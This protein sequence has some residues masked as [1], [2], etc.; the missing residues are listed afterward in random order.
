[1]KIVDV[2]EFYAERGGGVRTY[3]EQKLRAA[4]LLDHEVVVVAPGARDREEPRPGGRIIWLAA[5]KLPVDR[6]YHVFVRERAIWQV[7]DRERADVIEGS[8]PWG[9]GWAVARYR[10]RERAAPLKT[11]V[12]HHD[13]V[14]VYPQT[15]LGRA[16]GEARV[17]RL[18]APAWDYLR[19]LSDGF[20]ATIT[21][22]QSLARRLR[23]F[24]LARPIA[25]PF[26]VDKQVFG[27]ALPDPGLRSQLV[28]AAGAAAGAPLL[29]VLSRLHP[30]K[31]IFS[32]IE[33]IRRVAQTRPIAAV[34]FGDGPLRE[35]VKLAAKRA[36]IHLGGVV[37]DR[38]SLARALASADALLHGSAAETYGLVVAEALSA[39]LPLIVPSA[40]G[41][42]DLAEPAH[43]E[44]YPA[45][46]VGACADAIVR[47]LDRDR[48]RLRAAARD[49]AARLVRTTEQH[50]TDLFATYRQLRSE[51]E[52]GSSAAEQRAAAGG[53]PTGRASATSVLG[54]AVFERGIED[55][56]RQ[57]R[58]PQS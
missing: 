27:A 2:A 4:A 44:T 8:S 17:D 5:P 12:F 1:M 36:P 54:L 56:G 21:G 58:Q 43:A 48:P 14:A 22:G 20:D 26:G 7:L 50:F 57:E 37:R 55:A 32:L 10:S 53:R 19:M 11:F 31:R 24:G 25:V 51:R 47:L 34:I 18:C 33:A 35:L 45:G 41:A 46:D 49:A 15:L 23:E 28:A 13:P 52:A 29:V 30:E 16:L 6:R 40:G 42:S 9:G 38:A 3:V 39:G